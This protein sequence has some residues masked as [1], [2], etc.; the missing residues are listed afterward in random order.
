MIN[1]F[2]DTGIMDLLGKPI[3][4]ILVR[5]QARHSSIDIM[6]IF[7]PHINKKDRKEITDL[8]SSW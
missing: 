8:G 7:T 2:K 3:N 5:D 6:D 4:P 1:S